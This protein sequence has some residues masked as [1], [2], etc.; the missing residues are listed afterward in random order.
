MYPPPRC[1]FVV[2]T[3]AAGGWRY[4]PAPV[5]GWHQ[6]GAM[7][8]PWPPAVG[9]VVLLTGQDR[10]LWG[11]YRV[12]ER[13]WVPPVYRSMDWPAGKPVPAAGPRLVLIVAAV[14]GVF[15][16]EVPADDQD[17]GGEQP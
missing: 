4:R 11:T 1:E 13:Q 12:I 8:T 3:A 10:D 7:R 2:R 16:D 14:G 6:D 17:E 15:R 5:D 9:D